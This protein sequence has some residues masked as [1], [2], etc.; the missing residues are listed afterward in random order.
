MRVRAIL[1][2]IGTMLVLLGIFLTFIGY[3]ERQY[4]EDR[5]DYRLNNPSEGIISPYSMTD[6][7]QARTSASVITIIGGSLLAIGLG[8]ISGIFLSKREKT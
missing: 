8:I 6:L 1:L 4:F 7:E 2:S 5:I 3:Q